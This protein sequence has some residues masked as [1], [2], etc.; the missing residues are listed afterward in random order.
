MY[1]K[2]RNPNFAQD[3]YGYPYIAIEVNNRP[4]RISAEQKAYRDGLLFLGADFEGKVP[5]CYLPPD[6]ASGRPR[7]QPMYGYARDPRLLALY[8]QFLQE[9]NRPGY[10][11]HP[12]ELPKL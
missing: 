1:L 6:P 10:A 3:E 12:V 4:A 5:V 2:L 11:P 8:A 7:R 9:I